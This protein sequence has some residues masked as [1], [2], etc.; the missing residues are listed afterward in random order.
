MLESL[1]EIAA[2]HGISNVRTVEARWPPDAGSELAGEG[3]DVVLIAHVGY[4]VADIGPFVDALEAAARRICIA[5]LMER[6]PASAADPFWPLVHDQA[7]DRLPALPEFLELLARPRPTAPGRA[8][9]E[10]AAGSSTRGPPWAASSGASC[11]SIRADRK[12]PAS[13]PRS[14]TLAVQVD[15]GWAIADR[16]PNEI[17]V[18]SWRP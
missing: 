16:T 15:G 1:A 11:G 17:G 4:D 2:E 3:A 8:A 10:R 7:R 5:V 13:R 14:T 6:P 12:R 18:V 9:P